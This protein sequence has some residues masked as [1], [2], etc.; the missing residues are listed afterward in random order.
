LDAMEPE[1]KVLLLCAR[2]EF[3]EIHLETLLGLCAAETISW[4]KAL[5]TAKLHEVAPLVWANLEKAIAAGLSIPQEFD[6]RFQLTCYANVATKGRQKAKL[7]ETVP[8]LNAH[9]IDV[10]GIKSVALDL[11][12][13]DHPWYTVAGDADLV[14]RPRQDSVPPNVMAEIQQFFAGWPIEW[15][16]YE[17]HDVTMNGQLPVD[18]D[19]IWRDAVSVP[20]EGHELLLMSTEDM[21]LSLCINSARKRFFRLRSLVDIAET[22]SRCHELD[23]PTL[24]EKARAYQ[25]SH[26]AFTALFVTQTALE[27]TLPEGVLD[28]LAPA[29]TRTSLLKRMIPTLMRRQSLD[30]LSS[31]TGWELF[32]RKMGPSLLLPYASEPWRR[33][34]LRIRGAYRAWRMGTQ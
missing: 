19:R 20:F 27:C 31:Y 2:Q 7:A 25:C 3:A 23:W 34:G 6:D 21:L 17:H 12:V 26:F 9:S 18:F 30:S 33:I 29:S 11:L 24:V 13:Y 10:M 8:F 5:D 15:E 16:F 28:Q 4:E 14:L 22:V 32:G 1:D